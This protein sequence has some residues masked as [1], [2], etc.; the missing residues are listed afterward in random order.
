MSEKEKLEAIYRQVQELGLSPRVAAEY[1]SGVDIRYNEA[2]EKILPG[3]YVYT[4]G[5]I[6]SNIFFGYHVMAVVAYVED[7][8]VYA[9]CLRKDE[10]PWSSDQLCVSGTQI[11]TDG[12]ESTRKIL[13]VVRKTKKRAEAAQMCFE[14]TADGVR[15]GD[16]FLPSIDELL[17]LQV[18]IGAVN[19]A[20]EM[21]GFPALRG[22]LLSSTETEYGH[23][24]TLNM[25]TSYRGNLGKGKECTVVPMLKIFL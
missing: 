1:L 22:Y 5:K 11:L 15:K 12:Q 7:N 9:V 19:A 10:L 23:V 18:N 25:T 6:C 24:K 8:T 3:M 21:R 16:A 4:E 17:K 14:Y 2:P 20:L 13:D